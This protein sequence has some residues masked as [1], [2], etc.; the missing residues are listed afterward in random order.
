MCTYNVRIE[1]SRLE[2]D[3]RQIRSL[4][5]ICN[6]RCNV[7]EDVMEGTYGYLDRTEDGGHEGHEAGGNGATS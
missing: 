4:S 2:Y 3:S 6:V 7:M 1:A 5:N